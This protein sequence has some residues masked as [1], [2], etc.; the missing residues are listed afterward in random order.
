MLHL[1]PPSPESRAAIDAAL[2][3]IDEYLAQRQQAFD[4][5]VKQSP[6]L[7]KLFTV[8]LKQGIRMFV[9]ES[10]MH[11]ITNV[12]QQ[13][14]AGIL[15]SGDVVDRRECPGAI[16]VPAHRGLGI[17]EPQSVEVKNV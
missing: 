12:V 15:P 5:E 4:E 8:K 6:R 7:Q 11:F 1:T 16:P 3:A 9:A 10:E 13:G 14:F 17:P 2:V